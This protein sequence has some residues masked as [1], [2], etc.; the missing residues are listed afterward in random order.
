[1]VE[2]SQPGG[3]SRRYSSRGM[4]PVPEPVVAIALLDQRVVEVVQDEVLSTGRSARCPMAETAQR[5]GKTGAGN[6]L[7]YQTQLGSLL[8]MLGR[9]GAPGT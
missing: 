1:M 5:R 7:R 3:T 8:L 9:K 2:G 6:R 4:P